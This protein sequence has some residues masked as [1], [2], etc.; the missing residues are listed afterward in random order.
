MRMKMPAIVGNTFHGTEAVRRS[1]VL[2]AAG[3]LATAA[4]LG[5]YF[6]AGRGVWSAAA[7]VALALFWGALFCLFGRRQSRSDALRWA[8]IDGQV[9]ELTEKTQTVL[10]YLA[11]QFNE[12]FGNIRSENAQTQGILADA[13]EKLIASFTGLEGDARRQQELALR[14][15]RSEAGDDGQ[16][17][18][19]TFL[20]EVDTVLATFTTAA[21]NN[22]AVAGDLTEK[23]AEA[24]RQFKNVLTSLGEIRTIARQT[25]MLAL[26]AA[27]EAARAGTAGK[28]FAVVAEEVR[29][30]SV[31]SNRF[32]EQVGESVNGIA[33][34][35]EAVET[36]MMQMASSDKALVEQSGGKMETLLGQTRRFNDSVSHA[37]EEISELSTAVGRQVG[38]AVT[39]LQ[40]QDMAT[41]VLG[42]VNS[43]VDVLSSVL[44]QLA[45][46]PLAARGRQDDLSLDCAKRLEQFHQGLDA[47][48]ALIEQAQHSPVSQQ[49][50]SEGEIELF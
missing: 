10:G 11:R 3:V 49:S 8:A 19:E 38:Q 44:D 35:L 28:G 39:S 16:L 37:A 22:S 36:A 7:I 45:T 40:F 1:G 50:L 9:M 2:L 31:R 46:L 26:N 29:N 6:A 20:G 48:T 23:M 34:T 30:L 17:S 14:L 24:N 18:F 33:G 4:V 32:S 5:L 25:N 27:I 43:R 41:Q 15:T 21:R 12:Q 42:H 13:I 47:A